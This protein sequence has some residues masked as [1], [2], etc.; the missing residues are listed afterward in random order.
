MYLCP[1]RFLKKSLISGL[2]LVR[3]WYISSFQIEVSITTLLSCSPGGICKD[4]AKVCIFVVLI[5]KKSSDG[6][7][8]S[9]KDPTANLAKV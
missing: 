4:A 3:K 6:S 8:E 9:S 2:L 7:Q 5:L 1:V